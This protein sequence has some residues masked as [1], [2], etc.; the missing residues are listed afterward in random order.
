M[1]AGI[2]EH[3]KD[4]GLKNVNFEEILDNFKATNRRI[5]WLN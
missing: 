5:R 2:G 3:S 1:E 4:G